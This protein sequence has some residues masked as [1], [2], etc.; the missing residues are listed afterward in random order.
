[1]ITDKRIKKKIWSTRPWRISVITLFFLFIICAFFKRCEVFQTASTHEG[2]KTDWERRNNDPKVG[3]GDPPIVDGDY[4]NEEPSYSDGERRRAH[5]GK[6]PRYPG[7]RIPI[8]TTKVRRSPDDPLGR[9]RIV[10]LL[11]LYVEDTVDLSGFVSRLNFA[12]PGDSIQITYFAEQYKRIQLRVPEERLDQLKF[13]IKDR[14]REVKFAVEE[15]LV[16]SNSGRNFN[17]RALGD[18]EISWYFEMINAFDAWTVTQGDTAVLVAIIDDGFDLSHPELVGKVAKPWNV[19]QYSNN[20]TDF[21][22]FLKHGTHVASLAVGNVNNNFGALGIAPKCRFMPI[23]VA[24]QNGNMTIGAILD[25]IFYA[26]KNGASVINLSLGLVLP[27]QISSLPLK[28]Q[29]RI[30]EQELLNEAGMWEEVFEIL[31]ESDVFVIQAAGNNAILTQVDPMKR[32]NNTV[33]VGAID[34][35]GRVA[36]FSNYGDKVDIYAPGVEIYSALPNGGFGSMDGTSM[37]SP[38][39]AGAAALYRTKCPE[40]SFEEFKRELVNSGTDIHRDSGRVLNISRL[41]SALK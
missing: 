3:I 19:Q 28:E 10:D 16:R 8:D 39:V 31:V 17:D 4:S 12:F 34:R 29:K 5:Y 9:E 36:N 14:F 41:I 37:A 11:N 38:L 18:P 15:W 26:I 23:Q 21:K 33:V 20:V 24:D 2:R 1:M 6:L 30:A 32:S 25:A 40:C 13:E 35:N 27:N 7:R 22:G